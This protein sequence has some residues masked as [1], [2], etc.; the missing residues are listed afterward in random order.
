MN[1]QQWNTLASIVDET[2][3]DW[4][5][6]ELASQRDPSLHSWADLNADRWATLDLLSNHKSRRNGR[7]SKLGPLN[8]FLE[9][10]LA[11]PRRIEVVPDHRRNEETF[12]LQLSIATTL[13]LLSG[14]RSWPPPEP[15]LN[16]L[17][18]LTNPSHQ[19]RTEKWEHPHLRV[20]EFA[21]AYMLGWRDFNTNVCN[22]SLNNQVIQDWI[23]ENPDDIR[24]RLIDFVSI[25][26]REAVSFFGRTFRK[27]FQVEDS[28]SL[29][30]ATNI[31]QMLL[32]GNCR[33]AANERIRIE[34][35]QTLKGNALARYE[36][37][38]QR[39]HL[40]SWNPDSDRFWEFCN[41]AVKV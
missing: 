10:V 39:H 14:N 37:C 11:H 2:F 29:T 31:S 24:N 15:L 17:L 4:K 21:I 12:P 33:C 19:S 1:P 23:S 13:R 8:E 9:R 22:E 5:A 16:E 28:F 32:E 27:D 30:S 6:E 18:N 35:G 38:L 41:R 20:P 25:F 7:T 36:K 40:L 26:T 34:N 3:S